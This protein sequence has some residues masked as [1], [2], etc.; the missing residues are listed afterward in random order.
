MRA[1]R[2]HSWAAATTSRRVSILVGN[3]P[4]LRLL[5]AAASNGGVAIVVNGFAS[6]AID[7]G[8]TGATIA[9]GG[10]RFGNGQRAGSECERRAEHAVDAWNLR[11]GRLSLVRWHSLGKVRSS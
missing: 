7:T 1:A 3:A 4:A 9:G 6:N 2:Q 8:V 11:Y 5:P 10:A